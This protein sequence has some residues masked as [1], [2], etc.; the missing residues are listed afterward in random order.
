MRNIIFKLKSIEHT[1]HSVG[2][3][4]SLKGSINGNSFFVPEKRIPKHTIKKYDSLLVSLM[5]DENV[6]SVPILITIVERDLVWNDQGTSQTEIQITDTGTK[7]VV[8]VITVIEKWW[9]FLKKK[10]V[11]RVS[12]DIEIR[13]DKNETNLDYSI[14]EYVY[15]GVSGNENYNKHDEKI[16]SVVRYWNEQFIN[17]TNPPP[18]PLDPNLVKAIC[19]QE[20]RVGNDAQAMVDIMQVGHPDDPALKTLQG[21]LAEYWLHSGTVQII[22]Y[23]EAKVESEYDSVYWGT[24]WLYHRAQG[25][26]ENNQRFWRPWQEAVKR[27]GPGTQKY[28]DDVWQIYTEGIKKEENNNIKLWSLIVVAVLLSVSFLSSNYFSRHLQQAGAFQPSVEK[29]EEVLISPFN[30]KLK[31]TI[32]I[33]DQDW[34]ESISLFIGDEKVVLSQPPSEQS[35]YSI[36]FVHIGDNPADFLQVY[37]MTH[38]GHGNFYLYEISDRQA[39]LKIKEMAVDTSPDIKFSPKNEDEY[40][41]TNCGEVLEDDILKSNYSQYNRITLYGTRLILCEDPGNSIKLLEVDRKSVNVVLDV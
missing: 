2:Q 33:S 13:I 30:N 39:I 8:L 23:L 29:Q 14:K 7:E 18:T 16:K 27:Y 3:E 6:S 19:Y 38:H 40:G 9:L 21:I 10:A 1:G 31:V 24:R 17:D 32:E 20:S 12:L 4:I 37:G 41:Y 11:F 5:M 35:I 34:W 15:K 25:L 36:R 22:S 26:S 28:T